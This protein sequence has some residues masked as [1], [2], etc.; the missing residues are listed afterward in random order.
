LLVKGRA[1]LTDCFCKVRYCT[2]YS[3]LFDRVQIGQCFLARPFFL[4]VP[5]LADVTGQVQFGSPSQPFADTLLFLGDLFPA[6][7]LIQAGRNLFHHRIGHFKLL[8]EVED[9]SFDL[10]RADHGL[11][12]AQVL[13]AAAALVVAGAVVRRNGPH[14]A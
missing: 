1:P 12:A 8:Q 2:Y 7:R 4:P 14:R 13:D 6:P 9:L 3:I 11:L 10:F 5:F